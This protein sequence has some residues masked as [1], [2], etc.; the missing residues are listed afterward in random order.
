[1]RVCP[2]GRAAASRL[3][4]RAVLE[5][6][7]AARGTGDSTGPG[8]RAST[9]AGAA[10]ASM[11]GGARRRMPAARH[12]QRE[13]VRIYSAQWNQCRPIPGFHLDSCAGRGAR[14]A[15]PPFTT[16]FPPRG[17]HPGAAPTMTVKR[18]GLQALAI[19]MAA[20]PLA[21]GAFD[22]APHHVGDTLPTEQAR[23][24][25]ARHAARPPQP[26]REP[27]ATRLPRGRRGR[28]PRGHRSPSQHL[29]ARRPAGAGR[30]EAPVLEQPELRALPP[31]RPVGPAGHQAPMRCRS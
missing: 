22:I 3:P 20:I 17:G 19:A 27:D 29:L 5:D 31:G 16:T 8:C 7:R 14:A 10:F 15:F 2:G 25:L 11:D 18:T 26:W 30:L 12:L 24:M 9:P 23:A 28:G 21:A 4:G 6:G 13:A 1:M